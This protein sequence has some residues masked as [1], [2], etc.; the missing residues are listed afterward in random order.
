MAFVTSSSSKS[1]AVSALS[2]NWSGLV[3]DLVFFRRYAYGLAEYESDSERSVHLTFSMPYSYGL[4]TIVIVAISSFCSALHSPGV[5]SMIL[6]ST[7]FRCAWRCMLM[8]I[9]WVSVVERPR[10]KVVLTNTLIGHE[11]NDRSTTV[12]ELQ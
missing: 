4:R 2:S 7:P 11:S 5:C 1:M 9:G 6:C 12:F 3:S 10:R 8:T